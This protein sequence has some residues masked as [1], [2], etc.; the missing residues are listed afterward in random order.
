VIQNEKHVF[1]FPH[2]PFPINKGNNFHLKSLEDPKCYE[3]VTE[4]NCES[5]LNYDYELCLSCLFVKTITL[6]V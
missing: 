4:T 3:T 6:K 1:R 2:N 5:Q